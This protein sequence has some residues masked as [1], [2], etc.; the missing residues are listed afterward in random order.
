MLSQTQTRFARCIRLFGKQ[1]Y[2]HVSIGL[3]PEL[4]EVYA[5]SRPQHNAVLLG[6]LNKEALDR[7]TLRRNNSVPVV[8]FRISITE[9]EYEWITATIRNILY[10][11]QYM[12]NLFSVLTYP[13][14]KGF[15]TYRAYTCIE[16]V[17]YLLQH[18]GRLLD[19]PCC[20]YTPDE[21]LNEF[22]SDMIYKGDIRGC[23]VQTGEGSQYFEPFDRK[24]FVQSIKAFCVLTVRTCFRYSV[25]G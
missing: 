20:R 21:L 3:D 15:A 10:N 13:L 9:N 4:R 1:E 8:V 25:N 23:M 12:Y 18:T 22:Q 17:A 5:F 11:R 14:I 6:S 7:Y 19:K 2:N 16:F 24:M